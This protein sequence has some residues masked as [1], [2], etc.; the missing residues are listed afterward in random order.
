[1]AVVPAVSTD[2]SEWDDRG[3]ATPL[4]L[5]VFVIAVPLC[6][7]SSGVAGSWVLQRV[8]VADADIY[9]WGC[10]LMGS[11][12]AL[13]AGLGLWRAVSLDGEDLRQFARMERV[14]GRAIDRLDAPREADGGL[15]GLRRVLRAAG[16]E[17]FDDTCTWYV[18]HRDS[19]PDVTSG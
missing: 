7:A 5:V 19:I 16:R 14:F 6:V 18:R 4:R 9:A 12:L 17:Q 10:L 3:Q 1:L 11:L 13:L 2:A 15:E 8:G